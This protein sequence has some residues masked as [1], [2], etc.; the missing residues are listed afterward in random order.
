MPQK[1]DPPKPPPEPAP[2]HKPRRTTDWGS[3][4]VSGGPV[5]AV[6]PVLSVT[7]IRPVMLTLTTTASE[8]RAPAPPPSA[9]TPPNRD[10]EHLTQVAQL[11]QRAQQ[12]LGSEQA[13]LVWLK[14]P[15]TGLAG[16]APMAMMNTAA[17]IA[18]V[19]QLLN[20]HVNP[21][22]LPE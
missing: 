8:R 4:P 10:A 22:T 20:R 15:H 18:Q 21:A 17:E 3:L 6:E 16:A 14:T 5:H 1:P 7:R 12:L 11:L 2:E 19:L 13:A 9:S